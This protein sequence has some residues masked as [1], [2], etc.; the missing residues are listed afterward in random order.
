M[1][2]EARDINR[3]QLVEMRYVITATGCSRLDNN[4]SDGIEKAIDPKLNE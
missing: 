3:L 4:K 1:A 2:D